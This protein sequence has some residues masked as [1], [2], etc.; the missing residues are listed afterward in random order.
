MPSRRAHET[1]T[2]AVG[3]VTYH[4]AIGRPFDAGTGALGPALELFLTAGKPGSPVEAT[5]RDA[6]VIASLALQYGVPAA[7]IGRALTRDEAG[8]PAG[9]L[10]VVFDEI[11]SRGETAEQARER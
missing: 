11:V 8:A 9:P 4:A 7:E 1:V 5:A 2:F 6:G 10:G 3:N